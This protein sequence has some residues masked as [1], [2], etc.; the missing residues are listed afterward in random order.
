MT[1]SVG[2]PV[3]DPWFAIAEVEPGLHRITE[4]H[5]HRLIRANAFLVKGRTHDL[6]VD[7]GM[8]IGRLRDALRPLL[9]KPLIV[10]ATHA[11]V[12]HIGGHREFR[13]C[14]ILVHPAEAAD[15]SDPP[16]PRGLSFDQF[17][18]SQ[19]ETLRAAGFDVDGLL[20]DA[21]P[22]AGY[23]VD[24]YRCEG[25]TPTRMVDEGDS[26]DL[27]SRRFAVL[28]L[29]GHSPGGLGL[30]EAATGTLIAGDTLYDGILIDTIDGADPAAYVV[31]MQ[32]LRR[33]PVR[34]VHGGHRDSFGRERMLAIIDRY[35][36]GRDAGPV[37]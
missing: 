20:V 2:L 34:I 25:V 17:G 19:R 11:H 36:A 16:V 31:S 26:V 23:D 12:D 32:R 9:D 27:G 28:H 13:D 22:E 37:A 5:C 3:A 15:L 29:P 10:L 18:A 7:S 14:P 35:L 21:V 4:P 6:L 24:A 8:G 1:G 33:L 30:W